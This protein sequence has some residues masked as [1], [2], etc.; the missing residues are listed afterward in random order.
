MPP[1]ARAGN[2]LCHQRLLAQARAG[3]DSAMIPLF[4]SEADGDLPLLRL[5][6]QPF[7][8]LSRHCCA[9]KV[10]PHTSNQLRIRKSGVLQNGRP[11]PA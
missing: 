5:E 7:R 6:D 3:T 2:T 9:R 4:G 1:P 8:V 10:G 11:S